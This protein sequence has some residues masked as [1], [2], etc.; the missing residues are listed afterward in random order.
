MKLPEG[1]SIDW[2]GE[3]ASQ[4][5]SQ[6]AAADRAAGHHPGD[7]HHPLHHVHSFKWAVLMLV[8]MAMAPL[9]GLLAL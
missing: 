4:Q 3:Y 6:T 2:A 8:N 5:R 1:Y 7:L 9:G